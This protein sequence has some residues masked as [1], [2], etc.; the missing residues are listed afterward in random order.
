M[1]LQGNSLTDTVPIL[2]DGIPEDQT[3]CFSLLDHSSLILLT[4]AP[5]QCSYESRDD[6][7]ALLAKSY[8]RS[9]SEPVSESESFFPGTVIFLR[10]RLLKWLLG[11][12]VAYH[13]FFPVCH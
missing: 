12:Y 3:A 1:K 4:S 8:M 6:L 13:E 9:T 10:H 5:R 11:R 2:W 7:N